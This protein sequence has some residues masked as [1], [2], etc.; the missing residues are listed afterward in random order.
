M[1]KNGI[2]KENWHG[3]GPYIMG[4]LTKYLVK[5]HILCNVEA[6]DWREAIQKAAQPL[7]D[8][9]KIGRTYVEHTIE[10]VEEMGP[11]F[12]ITQGVALAHTRPSDDVK[13]QCVSLMTLATTVKFGHKTNDPVEIVFIL[14][15]TTDNGHIDAVM[16]IAQKLCEEG[17]REKI[18]SAQTAEE[19]YQLMM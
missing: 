10:K 12:V 15:A 14:A 8:A 17:I 18:K 2:P 1:I 3:R 5:E 9:G 4:E 7:V 16:H 11:Y 6:A 19:L 13:E